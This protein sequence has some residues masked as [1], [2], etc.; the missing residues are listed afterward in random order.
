MQ[1]QSNIIHQA[2]TTQ[3]VNLLYTVGTAAVGMAASETLESDTSDNLI[4]MLSSVLALKNI[5]PQKDS[6]SGDDIP[7][8]VG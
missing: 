6:P 1:Q 5:Q 2:T 7:G 3:G 8:Q 4:N